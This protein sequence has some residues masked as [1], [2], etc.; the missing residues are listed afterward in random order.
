MGMTKIRIEVT[1]ALVFAI[2]AV[3]TAIWPT[4]IEAIFE[5]S[6]DAGS[7]A[8]EWAIVGVFGL[9]AIAAAVLAG[10]DLRAIRST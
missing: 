7:G 5:E 6:P 8:L 9:L 10:R 3:V 1:L 4:W 2:L